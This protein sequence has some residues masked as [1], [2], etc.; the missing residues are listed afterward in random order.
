MTQKSNKMFEKGTQEKKFKILLNSTTCFKGI[1]KGN[2]FDEDLEETI[3]HA[4][5]PGLRDKSKTIK[6]KVDFIINH[7]NG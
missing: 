7:P 3:R 1:A 6:A 5:F 4:K 2:R